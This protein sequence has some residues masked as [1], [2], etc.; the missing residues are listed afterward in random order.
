MAVR[1]DNIRERIQQIENNP[2]NMGTDAAN[3]ELEMFRGQLAQALQEQ[4]NLNR[5]MDDLDVQT[6][7]EAY[8]SYA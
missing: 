4:Q 2:L 6:A 7:N 8:L 1:I 5:A 3:I